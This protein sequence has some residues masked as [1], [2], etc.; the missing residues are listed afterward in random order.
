MTEPVPALAIVIP[1]LN[2]TVR[3][4][5]CLAALAA[6]ALPEDVEAVVVDNGSSEDVAGTVAPYAV[7]LV[8]EAERGAAAA[9]N[10]GVAET[11]A[12]AIVFLDADCLPE[13]G[14]L[15]AVRAAVPRADLVGGRVDVFDETPPPRSGAEAFE[16]VLAFDQARY[17]REV[18]FSVTANLVT[19]R[20]VFQAIGGFRNGVSEDV[21]WC[22]R[23]T[24]AGFSLAYAPEMAVRHPT[25]AD[26]AA[27][28]RK[29]RRMTEESFA[30]GGGGRGARLRWA[31]RAGL[32]LASPLRD[33]PRVLRDPRLRDRGE[34]LR[35]VATLVRL[36]ALRAVWML[37]QAM[38]ATIR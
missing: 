27:L 30:L 29:W 24:R 35:A 8:H 19:R 6:E 28:R 3:L 31:L 17:I 10:R 33:L 25:R 22:Q 4:G 13:P 23:A 32:V 16:T 14:W 18:G 36:R 26:W 11:R 20:T 1:H 12:G 34:R 2:D 5:R 9:R 15:E 37:R 21:E 7:R 38:G